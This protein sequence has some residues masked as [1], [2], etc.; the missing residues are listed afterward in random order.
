MSYYVTMRDTF[1]SGW[2]KAEGL[3]NIYQVECDTKE[4][5]EQVAYAGRGRDEMRSVTISEGKPPYYSRRTHLVSEKHY[6]DLG[7]IWK[8]KL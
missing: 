8:P 3:I 1:M 7:K 5:A 6:N 2:G 4:Q